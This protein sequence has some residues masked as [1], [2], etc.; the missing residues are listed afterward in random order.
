MRKIFFV[1]FIFLSAVSCKKNNLNNNSTNQ[2]FVKG[3]VIVGIDST[4][5]IEQV[6]IM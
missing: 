6:L 1:T 2:N 3:D 4:T 5:T